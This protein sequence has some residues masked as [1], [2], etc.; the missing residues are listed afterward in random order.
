[1]MS[2]SLDAHDTTRVTQQ[3]SSTPQSPVTDQ[4]S[5]LVPQR[6]GVLRPAGDPFALPEWVENTGA[7]MQ[8]G[9]TLMDGSKQQQ[10]Q[11]M[12]SG[13]RPVAMPSNATDDDDNDGLFDFDMS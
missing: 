9:T 3:G 6:G 11:R 8:S 13:G 1:M 12:N 5:S 4:S 10:Q 2:R 7:G